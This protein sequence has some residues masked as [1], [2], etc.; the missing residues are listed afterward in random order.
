[1]ALA[2]DTPIGWWFGLE[3]EDG[4]ADGN[5]GQRGSD[6]NEIKGIGE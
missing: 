6:W 4:V 1:V 2:T 5:Y 3:S